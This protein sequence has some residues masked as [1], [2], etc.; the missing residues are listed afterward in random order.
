MTAPLLLPA[1]WP[2]GGAP[3]RAPSSAWRRARPWAGLL[4]GLGLA[5]WLALQAAD[6]SAAVAMQ[7][8]W[9]APLTEELVFRAGLQQQLQRAGQAPAVAV[10]APALGFA[11]LHALSRSPMLGLAVFAPACALGLLYQRSQSLAACV[12]AHAA[13]NLAWLLAARPALA[14]LHLSV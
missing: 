10:M 5:F 2:R 14:A 7:L 8:L 6:V 12:A 9:L 4:P 11:L 1:A 3:A 13:M